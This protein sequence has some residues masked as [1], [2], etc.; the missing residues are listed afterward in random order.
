MV[1]CIFESFQYTAGTQYKAYSTILQTYYSALD[2]TQVDKYEIKKSNPDSLLTSA[3]VYNGGSGELVANSSTE[4]YVQGEY[5]EG[6]SFIW[7]EKAKGLSKIKKDKNGN[8]NNNTRPWL[9]F[10]PSWARY[11]PG[12]NGCL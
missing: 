12:K 2:L 11:A 6:G 7:A 9:Y 8:D 10:A 4:G 1:I 5:I 3:M